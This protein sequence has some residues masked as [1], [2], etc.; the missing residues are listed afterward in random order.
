MNTKLYV[1]NLSWDATEDDLKQL[2]GEHGEVTDIFM[3]MDRESGRPRGFAFVTMDTVDAMNAATEA[4][5]GNEWMGRAMVVNEAKPQ[6]NRDN[7]GGGFRGG[8]SRGGRRD[9]NGYGRRED[10]GYGGYGRNRR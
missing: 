7:R 1:G 5:N 3:P 10:N 2:F 6:E 4:L 9:D 8:N